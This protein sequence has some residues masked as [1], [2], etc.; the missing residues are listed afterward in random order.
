MMPIIVVGILYLLNPTYM[1]EFIAP[2]SFPC[3]YI[4]LAVTIL[5]ITSGYFAMNKLSDIE[6]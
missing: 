6:I 1:G 3:G 2:S 5:L 4:A